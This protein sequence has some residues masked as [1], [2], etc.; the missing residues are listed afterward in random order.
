M[1]TTTQCHNSETPQHEFFTA[2]KT[3]NLIFKFM[4]NVAFVD[5]LIVSHRSTTLSA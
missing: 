1:Q 3:S 2:M 5:I 4:C